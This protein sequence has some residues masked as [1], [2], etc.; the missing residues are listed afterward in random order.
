M[1]SSRMRGKTMAQLAGRPSLRHIIERLRRV[2]SLDGIVVAT[3]RLEEDDVI[4]SC[5]RASGVPVY[6][7]GADDVLTRMLEAARMVGAGT[8]VRVTGDCPLIDPIVVEHAIGEYRTHRPDYASNSLGGY[9]YP[10]GLSVEVFARDLLASITDEALESRHREHVTLFFY[11]HPERF[12]LLAVK[13]PERHRRPDLRLTL[14]TPEDYKV[15]S[16]IYDALYETDHFFS[17]DAV[18]EYLD[19]HP[20]VAAINSGVQQL[21]P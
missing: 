20:E 13:P 21:A 10:I 15:I 5:A 6:R 18:L 3:T 16:T 11:E 8:I 14:D 2:P 12:R 4:A 1:G 9:K 19:G 17:L 7:G